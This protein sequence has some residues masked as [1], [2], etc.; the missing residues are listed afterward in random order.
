MRAVNSRTVR[1]RRGRDVAEVVATVYELPASVLIAFGVSLDLRRRDYV[2]D[3]AEL[4]DVGNP[5]NVPQQGDR[6]E[7]GN[8]VCKLT[9]L[10]DEEVFRWTNHLRN[11]VRVHTVVTG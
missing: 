6:I 3:L 10:G 4:S 2:I 9:P 1:Y 8:L 5:F 7:D 11:E